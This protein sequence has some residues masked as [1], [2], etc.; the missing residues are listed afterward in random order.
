M[1]DAYQHPEVDNALYIGAQNESGDFETSL[2]NKK[3]RR[4]YMVKSQLKDDEIEVL[5]AVDQKNM[6]DGVATTKHT[7]SKKSYIDDNGIQRDLYNI[8]A[9]EYLYNN[10]DATTAT[11]LYTTSSAVIHLI[12]KPLSYSTDD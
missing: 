6:R 5:D 10:R 9:R 8:Q 12:D 2:I 7:V 4:F 1:R 3:T 11:E